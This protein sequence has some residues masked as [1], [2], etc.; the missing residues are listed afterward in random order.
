MHAD[1]KPC[2]VMCKVRM[3]DMADS[4]CSTGDAYSESCFLMF[5]PSWDVML[6][7]CLVL[8]RAFV[9]ATSVCLALSPIPP[10]ASLPQAENASVYA[11]IGVGPLSLLWLACL[12]D[13][14]IAASSRACTSG[15]AQDDS[16]SR[17]AA[18][19]PSL[20]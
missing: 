18:P 5:C 1:L 12:Y 4:K 2:N 9:L 8:F 20:A 3:H 19:A 17:A 7:G 15:G 6:N 14:G 13:M 10:T 11:K 16:G